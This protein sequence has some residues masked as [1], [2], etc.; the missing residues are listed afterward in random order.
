MSLGR[1]ALLATLAA[2]CSQMPVKAQESRGSIL[3][4]VTDSTDAVVL[5]ARVAATNLATNTV[6]SSTTNESGNYEIPYLLPGR[7]RVEVELQGFNKAVREDVE[8]RVSDRLQLNFALQLGN[9]AESIVVTGETPLL[10]TTTASTGMI[11]DEKRAKELP[12]IGGNAFYLTRLAAGITVSGGHSAGNPTDRGAGTGIIVNGTKSNSSEVTLDGAPNMSENSA[13][14]SPMQDLVQEFKVQSSSYDATL[15]RAA[16]A[17]VNVSLKSGANDLH[18]TAYYFDSRIRAVPWFSNNWLYDPTTGPITEEK[19]RQANPGWLHQR[20]GAT[21][22]GPI[23]IPKL[24]DGRNR[25]FWTFGYEGLHID[26]Q[27]TF[28]AT[29]PTMAQRQGD[30][31]ALLALGSQYQ[32]YDPMTIQPAANGRFSRQPLPGNMI[33]PSRLD[34]IAQKLLS[35]YPEPNTTGTR[36]FRQNYFGIQKEPKDYQGYLSRIDHTF[37]EKNRAFVRLNGSDFLTSVQR[38][39]TIAAGTV[40]TQRNYGAVVDDVHVFGPGLLL[41]VR[42]S[43]TYFRP[44]VQPTS[45]GF[46]IATLGFSP[47]LVNEIREKNQ[48]DAIA[49]PVIAIDGGAY[50][51]LS[52]DGGNRRSTLYY[53]TMG[54]IT[55]IAGSHSMRFGG[56]FRVYREN[57]YAYG[58]VAPLIEFTN[59][60]AKGPLD[61]AAGAPIGQGL[62]SSLLGIPTGGRVN[63]NAA[64]SQRNNFTALFFQDDWK[65]TRKLT[66]NVGIRWEYDTPVV[67]S[68]NRSIRGF[69]FTTESPI[70]VAARAAYARNP[71]PEV[72][73]SQF[74]TLGGL[75]FAGVDGQPNRLWDAD[76][77]NFAPRIGLAYQISRKTVLRTGYGIFFDPLGADQRDVNQGGFNQPTNIVPSNNNGVD[78]QATLQ[79]PFPGGFEVPVGAAAGLSTFLGRA[80]SYFYGPVRNPYMQRWSF[81][82]QHEMPGSVLLDVTYLGNRGTRLLANR[83]WN[84]IPREYL[85][86]SPVR[87]QERIDWLNAQVPN[88]FVGLPGFQGTGMGNN[89]R[90]A[91]SQLLRPYPQFTGITTNDSSGFSWY[92]SLQVAAQK[93]FSKGLTMNLSYTWSKFMEAIT[94]LNAQDLHPEH[95][96]SDEDFPH[97]LT[98]SG[99]GELPFGRGKLLGGGAGPWVNSVIGGWQLQGWYELQSGQALGFGNVPFNGNSHD[100]VLPRAER[101]PDRWFNTEAGFQRDNRLQ[102][103]SNIRTMP[104]RFTGVRGDMINN[105]DVSLFKNFSVT[106]RYTVQFR[107]E[108]YNA[109]NKVQFAN[110]NTNPFNT[111]FGTITGE[112][113]HGQRQMTFALKLIF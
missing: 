71:L 104:S 22:S 99:I 23:R 94:Y 113:G 101:S 32:I 72:P 74:R 86:T 59:N 3:G 43:I 73:V 56:D 88:P 90:V 47:A 81:S 89:A 80:V 25:S 62:A 49:F 20:W 9:V 61:S 75:T 105:L 92:H 1:V 108:S 39:P 103:G 16:G 67:E 12:I 79:N 17:V 52:S 33:P 78:F 36:D 112:K 7:Y 66:V 102:L 57:G 41:N 109:L 5:G 4:R 40:T 29:V 48:G 70:S 97:R 106:E 2:V 21:A 65:A 19:R 31:S 58:N 51:Q 11:L 30:F 69:D 60:W 82:V 24:Y 37:S 14:F 64:R 54:T 42:S 85:S 46:D 98:I 84:A 63:I 35:Y 13:A 28:N 18:G 44:V 95:V 110:P 96:V 6:V 38:L 10:E 76:R 53:N 111:A 26:R 55:R 27:P 34:P 50:E 107:V 45:N 91:R 83:E 93:R 87:D 100:I 68:Y 15:G 77:N 8:L